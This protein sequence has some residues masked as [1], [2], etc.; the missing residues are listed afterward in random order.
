MTRLNIFKNQALLS[1][2]CEIFLRQF[3]FASRYLKHFFFFL[4]TCYRIMTRSAFPSVPFSPHFYQR[5]PRQLWPLDSRIDNASGQ[6][7][8]ALHKPKWLLRGTT[9]VSNVTWD[10][11]FGINSQVWLKKKNGDLAPKYDFKYLCYSFKLRRLQCFSGWRT[12]NCQSVSSL[13]HDK[14]NY[15]DRII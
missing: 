8:Q 10:S 6:I 2:F 11:N 15:T 3:S 7:L 4:V 14:Q 1:S 9:A 5:P 13:S 12:Y